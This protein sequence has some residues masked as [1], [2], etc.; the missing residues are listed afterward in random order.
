M[1][2]LATNKKPHGTELI[3]DLHDCNP[4]K[5]NRTSIKKYFEERCSLIDMERCKLSWWD[6][7]GVPP[8]EQQTELHLKGTKTVQFILTSNIVFRTPEPLEL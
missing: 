4:G 1:N 2:S 5:F 7:V 6:E 8:E 3:L